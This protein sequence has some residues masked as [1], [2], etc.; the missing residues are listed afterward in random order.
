MEAS[1][2][3]PASDRQIDLCKL[4][5]GSEGTLCFSTE[6]KLNCVPLPP[7][8]SGLQCA[9]FENVDEALRATLIAVEHEPFA[10][11]LIDRFILEGASR[12]REQ[13]KNADFVEGTPGAILITRDSW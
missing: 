3:D 11:E 4:L 12:N 1:V 6:I 2:F 5:A 13:A 8:I 9:H 10:V 7:P